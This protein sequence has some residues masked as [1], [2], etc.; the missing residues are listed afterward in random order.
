MQTVRQHQEGGR[1][2]NRQTC[3]PFTHTKTNENNTKQNIP[4][5]A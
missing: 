4:N 1:I 3:L 2:K 5:T